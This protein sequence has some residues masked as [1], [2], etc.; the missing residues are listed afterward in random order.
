MAEQKRVRIGV[1][2]CW[3]GA[4]LASC[5]KLAGADIVAACDKDPERYKLI[6][7]HLAEGAV[8]YDDFDKFIE[9]DM[10]GVLL[11]NYYCEHVPY[12]LRV[13]EKGM[14]VLSECASCTTMADA[15]ALVRAVENSKGT[16]AMIENYPYSAACQ[17]LRR[18]YQSGSLG[19]AVYCEGEYVHPMSVEEHRKYA[20]FP[21]HWRN[22]IPATYYNTHSLG[23]LMYAT[24]S[25]P[26]F[27][28]AQ[29]VSRPEAMEGTYSVT[30]PFALM[31]CKMSDGSVFSFSAW[32]NIPGH[33]NWYRITG[34]KGVAETVRHDGGKVRVGYN[35]FSKPE[36]EEI[37]KMYTPAFPAYAE[38]AKKCGHGGG[39]FFVAKEFVDVLEGKKKPFFDVYRATAM[40][41]C[42]ILGWRSCLEGGKNF[43]IPDFHK[44]EDKKRYENDTASPFVKADG[45]V[46]IP[47][48]IAEFDR[49]IGI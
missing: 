40:A 7:P 32:A 44:E 10:D 49:S 18:V 27:V 35:S 17:E 2:G 13:L 20:S 33:G 39:D 25:M 21:E 37:D 30:D 41:A 46:D 24:E 5:L 47:C 15:V 1:F 3:R 16:Y 19:R 23:P 43:R 38:E 42:G 6:E 9:H 34:T 29:A 31:T 4:H 8:F 11:A 12:A 45:S 22:H 28:S 14:S 26:V 36:G 48:S